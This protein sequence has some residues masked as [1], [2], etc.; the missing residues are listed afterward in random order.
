MKILIVAGPFISLREPYSGGTEA[1]IVEHANEL[2]RLGHTVD[3]I[4]K[5]ADEKNLFQII[6]FKESPLSMK[7]DSFRACS[8]E[9]GQKHFQTLQFSTLDIN[10]YD[11]IHYNSFIPEIY[12][13]GTLF[14]IPGVL[15][16]HLPPTEKF[17]LMYGFFI[18]HTQI[19]PIAISK[20]MSRE[21]KKVFEKDVEVILNG[22]PLNQWKLR[23]RKSDGFFLWSGRIAEEKNVEA[24]V[25]LANYLQKPLKIVGPI[26][27]KG[28][29]E[30]HVKPHLNENIQYISH[31]TQK[32]LNDLAAK[33]SVYLATA[34]WKEPFGL[35]TVEMLASGLPVIGFHTAIPSELRRGNVSV[36]VD[37][38]DW[39]DLIKP[40][41]F[42]KNSSSRD[43]RAFAESFDV[44][45]TTAE[46]VKVYERITIKT[47]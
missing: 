12:A 25:S 20:R 30:D 8:E 27:N 10:C 33:A 28:Y 7:D 36:A 6:E 46:Y 45:K 39:R 13:V 22:I 14:K 23:E 1:F 16:L 5:D 43:C 11:L 31:V 40:L 34:R 44:K 35:S 2:V 17:A 42:V 21:W 18:K 26:F 24:A 47:K 41:E 3:I 37:S 9:L 4:A 29:F 19:L 15:T 32:Q 38:A